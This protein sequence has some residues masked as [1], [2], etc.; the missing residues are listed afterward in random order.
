[1]INVFR[2]LVCFTSAFVL[3]FCCFNFV[4]ADTSPGEDFETVTEASSDPVIE[5][6]YVSSDDYSSV[7]DDIRSGVDDLNDISRD[8]IIS[9]ELV[10]VSKTVYRVSASDTTGLKSILLGLFGDYETVV[11]DYEYRNNNNTYM[12]HSID[13]Q[14]DYAWMCAAACFG[15]VLWCTFRG[16]VAIL[17]RA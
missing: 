8:G 15:I 16:V 17:C 11:T 3:C 5:Y 1:M 10:D 7:L 12:S 9:G 14:P 2:K 4:F 13:I 6:V